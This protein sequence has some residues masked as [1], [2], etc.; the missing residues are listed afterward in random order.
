MFC[1]L[2]SSNLAIFNIKKHGH[3]SFYA[4]FKVNWVRILLRFVKDQRN[5]IFD[6]FFSSWH[7]KVNEQ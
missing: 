2:S 1:F 6:N 7:Y 5:K 3:S 4:D